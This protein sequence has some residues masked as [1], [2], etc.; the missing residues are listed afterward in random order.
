[1]AIKQSK[2]C[3]ARPAASGCWPPRGSDCRCSI[4]SSCG[5]TVSDQ[6]STP[7][8][9]AATSGAYPPSL[10]RSAQIERKCPMY[11]ICE[12]LY[13]CP[14]TSS[15]TST[16]RRCSAT[17]LRIS[18]PIRSNASTSC[19]PCSRSPR[20]SS[21]TARTALCNTV[22]RVDASIISRQRGSASAAS[23]ASNTTARP[24]FTK[25]AK[26]HKTSASMP[27]DVGG[28]SK[29]SDRR[30]CAALRKSPSTSCRLPLGSL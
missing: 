16:S 23:M 21:N 10:L 26:R 28:V 30:N 13:L 24:V 11:P 7:A 17:T 5:S 2:C 15:P 8:R 1:M 12:C 27:P 18:G 20:T 19:S 29:A 25:R 4:A 9:A 22:L 3:N 6:P 14:A